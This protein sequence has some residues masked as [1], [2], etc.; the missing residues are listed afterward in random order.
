MGDRFAE[1]KKAPVRGLWNRSI[2]PDIVSGR[3]ALELGQ[4]FN[5][6]RQA[7][8]FARCR[9]AMHDAV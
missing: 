1:Y 8:H 4:R 3:S 5:T 9:V 7:R 2:R 6:M